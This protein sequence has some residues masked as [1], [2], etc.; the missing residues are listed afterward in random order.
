MEPELAAPSA[1]PRATV[2]PFE[3][4]VEQT[5]DDL[6]RLAVRLTG[7]TADAADVV[8]TA[9]LRV[10]EALR[11]GTFR[12]ESRIETWLYRV[13]THAA[14]D[15]RRGQRRRDSLQQQGEPLVV[16]ARATEAAV[17]LGE[18]RDA[19][20]SLPDDQR[21]ALVLKELH[22]L[23][24]KETAEVMERSEGSVEQLLVRARAALKK[25]FDHE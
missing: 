2:P 10:F 6:Y 17:E 14:F 16:P 24:G 7:S 18:L 19:L 12:G 13:V 22:G 9:Y 8:Q 23:S 20:E 5:S 25:R 3:V 4:L 11:D 21:A 15:A 1:S